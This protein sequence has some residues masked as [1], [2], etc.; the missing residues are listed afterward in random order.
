ME[1]GNDKTQTH[2]VLTKGTMVSHYRIIEK[3]GAGGM[4]EVYL[5]EDI[6]LKRQ[7]ALKFLPSQ[8]LSDENLKIR[9]KREA[10]AAAKLNHPNIVT[11]HEVSEYQNRPFFAM[12]HVVGQSLRQMIKENKLTISV[13][14][15]LAIQLCEGLNKAHQFGVIHRDIKPAN[16]VIDADGRP[17]LLDFG[18]A[19]MQDTEKI[20]RTGSTIGTIGYMSPEQIQVR[21]IDERSDLFSLGVVLYE[22]ITS[23]SPF[24]KDTEAATMNAIL[25]EHP[26]PLK[27]YK[28]DVPDDLQAI[29]DNLLDKDASMRYQSASGIIPD[30]KRIKMSLSPTPFGSTDTPSTKLTAKIG[31]NGEETPRHRLLRSLLPIFILT[32]VVLIIFLLKIFKYDTQYEREASAAENRLAIMYFDNFEDKN[33]PDR[34]GEIV[35]NLVITDLS[36]SQY[37]S[38]VSSQR[39]Y[40][41]LKLLGHEGEKKINSEVA[42]QVAKKAKARV[43][44]MGSLLQVKPYIII[45]SQLV[46]VESGQ[47]LASQ[48]ISGG[49]EDNI[50]TIVDKLAIEIKNDLSLPDEA[51]EENDVLVA[52]VT[53]NSPEAYRYYLEGLD[54]LY[55]H[56]YSESETALDKAIEYDSTFAMVYYWQA[57]IEW[58]RGTPEA[59]EKILKAKKYSNNVSRKEKYYIDSYY[60]RVLGDYGQAI[61]ILQELIDNYPDEKE[62]YLSMGMLKRNVTRDLSGAMTCFEKAIELDPL[63][64]EGYNQLAY[65][66]NDLGLFE[67]AMM[68]VNKYVEIAPEEANPYDSKGEI[69]ALNGRLDEAIASYQKA[70][71]IKPDFNISAL[72]NMY[73]F[74]RNYAKAESLYQVLIAHPDK[75]RRSRGRASLV[76]ILMHRGKFTR[77]L[78]TMDICIKT[79]SMELGLSASMSNKMIWRIETYCLLGQLEAANTE[80]ERLSNFHTMAD[81]NKE[82]V[83]AVKGYLTWISAIAGDFKS[84]DTLLDELQTHIDKTDSSQVDIYELMHARVEC[85]KGNFKNAVKYYE[86]KNRL[87]PSFENQFMIARCL[88]KN[89]KLADAVAMY[90]KA[91]NRY[92]DSRV[93]NGIHAVT[94]HY[95]L[96]L[97]YEKSGWIGKAIEQY[98][99]FLDI[100]KDADPGINE[101]DDAEERLI[102]LK[103]KS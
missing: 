89:N 38:I 19:A 86:K 6:E 84:A 28:A 5:A 27:R 46:E 82:W 42:T 96:A 35:T 31:K 61:E 13:I 54:L 36:E 32:A 34:L 12:E 16:I 45:T 88:L 98:D 33:D 23:V 30:L 85:E 26:E 18:L 50:F 95:W 15:D 70:L 90:E 4:G 103:S 20:T 9:F 80:V 62:A 47:V 68:A 77:A 60:A 74:K 63:S 97:A 37:M 93:Y 43:M 21:E 69:Y 55:K 92:D 66:Y 29:I 22:M 87:E 67:K 73:L 72:A 57:V 99:I 44:L 53:T 64:K 7:V 102:R 24:R 81:E 52:D 11:I 1:N 94:V 83:H 17:K 58:W 8:F 59:E 48:H 65:L 40:D 56:Y 101:I 25:N 75:Y 39:L 91:I 49:N 2:I 41:I 51:L 71:Q 100:W 3:I 76:D 14:I 10:Q 78:E 79:D